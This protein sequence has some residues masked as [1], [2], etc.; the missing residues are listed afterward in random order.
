M[1]CHKCSSEGSF[2]E[3]RTFS[4]WYCPSCKIEIKSVDNELKLSDDGTTVTGTITL[5]DGVKVADLTKFKG[6]SVGGVFN[7]QSNTGNLPT[8]EEIQKAYQG[9]L[10]DTGY[11]P[12]FDSISFP[13]GTPTGP[14]QIVKDSPDKKGKRP[15]PFS[16]DKARDDDLVPLDPEDD[17]DLE[18]ED[19][20]GDGVMIKAS[21]HQHSQAF[22]DAYKE[23]KTYCKNIKLKYGNNF[24]HLKKP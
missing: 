14:S 15:N 21:G 5:P 9:I 20:D 3:Y 8:V 16:K 6:F 11:S 22:I 10:K 17:G 18:M 24:P 19:D 7:H 1:K 13:T 12:A 23:A 4:Y 2:N